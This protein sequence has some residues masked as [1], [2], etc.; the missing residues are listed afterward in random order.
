MCVSFSDKRAGV[1]VKV[2]HGRSKKVLAK[3]CKSCKAGPK[4]PGIQLSKISKEIDPTHVK[5]LFP[6]Q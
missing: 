6:G 4:R 3:I 2:V 1:I 5:A